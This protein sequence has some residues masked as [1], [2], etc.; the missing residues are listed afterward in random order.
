MHRTIA[1]VVD[2]ES[3]ATKTAC[4]R[5]RDLVE[6][7]VAAVPARDVEGLDVVFV[8]L[9]GAGRRCI[10]PC[11]AS[12]LLGRLLRL[13]RFDSEAVVEV[14]HATTSTERACWTA[15]IARVNVA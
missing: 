2:D 4:L 1:I 12:G 11:G 14:L 5:W 9:D 8:L 7:R 15:S 13:P 6:V 10:V 3:I